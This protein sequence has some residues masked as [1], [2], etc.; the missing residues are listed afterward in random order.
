M[1]SPQAPPEG[2]MVVHRAHPRPNNL[3]I[4]IPLG[5]VTFGTNPHGW[6]TSVLYWCIAGAVMVV[7][8][9]TGDN[10]RDERAV[11]VVGS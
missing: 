10:D 1:W 9:M 11:K 2:R 4:P 8:G 7:S 5:A 6:V 3:G